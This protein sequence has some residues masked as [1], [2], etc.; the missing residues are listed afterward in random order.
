MRVALCDDEANFCDQIREMLLTVEDEKNISCFSSGE[1]LLLQSEKNFYD[2]VYLDI[3]MQGING[4]EVAEKLK[5]RNHNMIIIFVSSYTS[6]ISRAFRVAA[7]QFLIK[8]NVDREAVL[9]EYHRAKE[10][11]RKDHDHYT[12]KQ[13]TDIR[14]FEIYEITYLESRNRHLYL[15]TADGE[16][17]EFR[18]KLDRESEKLQMYHF[19]RVHESYLVNMAYIETYGSDQ[20]TLKY[21]GKSERFTISRRYRETVGRAYN[22]Y[23]AGCSI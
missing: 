10:R 22:L 18:G 7:F 4:I 6:Y 3:E 8:E 19:V 16:E 23:I 20:L 5:K 12:I 13:K 21:N 2:I 9:S 11:Y 1:E 17:Y 14:R 15:N